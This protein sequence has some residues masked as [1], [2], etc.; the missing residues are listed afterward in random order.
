[1]ITLG[2]FQVD[3]AVEYEGPF[4]RP[5]DFLIGYDPA[6]LD[7]NRDWLGHTIDPTTGEMRMSFHSF[8]LRTGRHTILIDTCMGNGKERPLRPIGHHRNTNFLGELAARGVRPEEVDFVMCTHLH[9]DHVGWNT[10]LQDGRWAPT[11]PNARYVMART[12][13]EHRDALHA[14]GDR[15]MHSLAFADSIQPLV[16]AERALVVDD[17]HELESGVWLQACPGHTP[18][19]V[20]INV[21]SRGARGVF[22]GDVLHSPL[23]LACPD[24]SSVA[25][26]DRN[27][28][29]TSR[30]RFIEQHADTGNLVMPA[31]FLAPSAGRI[32]RHGDAFAFVDAAPSVKRGN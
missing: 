19:N 1:M 23:Q 31:H 4:I 28:S 12:E 26:H 29:F 13:F 14:S 32:V 20:V 30:R 22:S 8:V 10:T 17:D 21:E 11:F 9:W 5:E 3:R 6:V 15:S 16:R 25:C 24:L 27:L 2:D 7:R 18:G